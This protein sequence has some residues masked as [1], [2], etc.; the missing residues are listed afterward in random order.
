MKKPRTREVQLPMKNLT[1]LIVLLVLLRAN[2][3]GAQVLTLNKG[4]HICY[5]GNALAD[6]MQHHGFLET[7]IYAK[8]PDDDLVFRN[9]AASGDEVATWHRSENFG[10]RDD[11]LTKTKA[12]V[13]LAFYGFN[14]SFKGPEGLDK[15]KQ[16]LDKL[17]KEIKAKD[18][19]GKSAPRIALFSPIAN[20]TLNDPNLPD[21]T[22]NNANL[23]L[24]T[25]AMAEVAKANDVLFV[26][27]FTVSQRLYAEAAKQGHSLTFNPFLLTEAGDK[28]LAPEIFQALF[29]EKAPTGHLEKLRGDDR[30]WNSRRPARK[31][32]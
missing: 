15:F 12:D 7:L 32:R 30:N 1:G 22:T 18:Y 21:P 3:F 6:R 4:D 27:L 20:E 14:E 10:S 29:N 26:D 13:V 28:A 23:K 25:A 16:D 2:A 8:F 24:Y 9:L 17:L 19:S 5:L 31:A 11:W